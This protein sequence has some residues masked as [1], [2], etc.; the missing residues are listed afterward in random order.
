[1]ERLPKLR[2]AQQMADKNEKASDT[3][4]RNLGA[5]MKS[6]GKSEHVLAK[7]SGVS[8]KTINNIL[9]RRSAPTI[10]TADKL[11]RPFGL[12]SWHLMLPIDSAEILNT[13]SF[14]T[15]LTHYVSSTADGREY[16]TRVADKEAK[17]GSK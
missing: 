13:R 16:I 14:E 15:L 6:S 5:L 4:A 7:E 1:M 17:Y 9:N 8:Q 2:G 10:D 11:A 12:R 3:L